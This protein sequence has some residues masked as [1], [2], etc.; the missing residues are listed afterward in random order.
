MMNTHNIAR[1]DFLRMLGIS[2]AALYVPYRGFAQQAPP[3]PIQATRLT[4]TITMLS[5]NGGNV[6]VAIADDSLLMVDAGLPMRAE[7]LVKTV[8]ALSPRKVR[9]LF[10]THF[11]FDHVGAN[12]ILGK[13]GTKIMAHENVKR[14]LSMRFND[15]AFGRT[16]EPLK[17]EGLPM[18]TY[19]SGGRL[20]F[21]KNTV[22]YTHIAESHTDGDTYVF[23]PEANILQTGDLFWNGMYPVIDYSAKGWIGGMVTAADEMAKLGDANTRIIPGHGPLATKAD[24]KA[25]RDMLA[26]VHERLDPM[27]KQG[28]TVEEV[29]AA[30]PTKDLD[31]K[32]G[33]ARPAAGFLRQAYPSLVRRRS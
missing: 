21:G 22:V 30:A 11:H 2:A 31:E 17:P 24:L 5:G 29:L 32:W 14:I 7:E 6:G 28:K 9:I 25:F 12:E 16:F 13:S 8:E 1:R 19:T 33:K 27:V 10:N 15:E 23:F 3:P 20:S 4:D 26:T 18:E